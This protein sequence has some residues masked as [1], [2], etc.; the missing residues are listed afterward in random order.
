MVFPYL[1][2]LNNKLSKLSQGFLKNRFIL[3]FKRL[4]GRH[5][6]RLEKICFHIRSDDERWYLQLYFGSKLTIVF[7][8]FVYVLRWSCLLS[9]I[10][11][12]FYRT[13]VI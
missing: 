9:T 5:Q 3:T 12:L 2:F 8:T 10:V 11:G 6:Q 13:N 4:F 7:Y 1:I